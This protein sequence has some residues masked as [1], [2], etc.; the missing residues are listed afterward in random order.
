PAGRGARGAGRPVRRA[1]R[2][3]SHGELSPLLHGLRRGLG[4]RRRPGVDRLS[5]PLRAATGGACAMRRYRTLV[6]MLRARAEEAPERRGVLF[7]E[8]RDGLESELSFGGLD[9]RARAIG[10]R[11]Q[12]EIAPGE[13]ALL[14]YPPGIELIAALFGC[15]YAGI[16]AVVTMPPLGRR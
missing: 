16:V 2:A 6:D 1:R 5:I 15:L 14:L 13:R 10:A 7:L 9:S 3:P 12:A 8:D 4:F 11:L